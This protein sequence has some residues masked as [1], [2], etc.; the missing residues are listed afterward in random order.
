[1]NNQAQQKPRSSSHTRSFNPLAA[2]LIIVA[3][4]AVVIGYCINVPENA[5]MALII[6]VCTMVC[7]TLILA[8]SGWIYKNKKTS[9]DEKDIIK[10]TENLNTEMIIWSDDFEYVYINKKLR[11]LLGITADYSDKKEGVWTAFGINTPDP[12]ALSKIVGSNS[13]E[14]TFRNPSGAFVSIA[15]STSQVKKYKKRSVYLST[16]FNLTELKKMRVNL[17][18]ANDFFHSAMELAEIGLVICWA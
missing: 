17:A 16:G 3:A 11:D 13:Y 14:S 7:A 5:R 15:W 12:T 9:V 4:S 1:M 10:I 6:Y 18:N 2:A 8:I